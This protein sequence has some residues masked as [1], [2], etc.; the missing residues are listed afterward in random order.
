M[1][2]FAPIAAR[3]LGD[4][5]LVAAEASLDVVFQSPHPVRDVEVLCQL[6]HSLQE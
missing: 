5:G 4:T 3:L 1:P 2:D 6:L